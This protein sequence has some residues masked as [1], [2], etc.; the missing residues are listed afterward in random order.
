MSA[1]N[2]AL[3]TGAS[4]G[5]GFELACRA[6]EDGRDI[7]LVARDRTKLQKAAS[8]IMSRH[9][10]NCHI[11]SADLST[12]DGMRFVTEELPNQHPE[13]DLVINC[14]GLAYGG[15]LHR[16]S[17]ED[18]LRVLRVNMEAVLRISRAFAAGFAAG[19]HGAILNVSSLAAFQPGPYL[20]NYYASKAYVLSLTEALAR[21]LAPHGVRISV[22][23]PGTTRTRFHRKAGIDRTDLAKGLFGIV[24][25]PVEVSR[26][27]Y[28]GLM[29]GRVTIVPGAM[30]RAAALAVRLVPR[31]FVTWCTALMN[32]QPAG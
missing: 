9:N 12:E 14:A 20:A 29:R 11:H 1:I 10:V 26:L 32:R 22:L 13:I 17:A 24:M 28:R 18:E 5:I 8:L 23:C 19:R 7:V 30:N 2:K 15:A 27:A 31:R 3:V 21:E 25:D 16:N 4:D 6:A